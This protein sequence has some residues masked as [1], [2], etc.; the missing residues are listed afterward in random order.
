ME[1]KTYKITLS[2][3]TEI[4]NLKLNGNNYISLEKIDESVFNGTCS[5]V[6]ISDGETEMIHPNME[7]VQIV[8]QF[9]GEYWIVLRDISDE[10]IANIKMLSDIEYIAMMTNVEL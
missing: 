6:I 10:E 2:D 3:G 4:A 1:E 5:P 9:E 8:E 7:L